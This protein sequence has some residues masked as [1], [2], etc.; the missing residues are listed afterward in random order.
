MAEFY[1]ARVCLSFCNHGLFDQT[2]QFA[3]FKIFQAVKQFSDL[4]DSDIYPLQ[5][6]I[7]GMHYEMT[8]SNFDFDMFLAYYSLSEMFKNETEISIVA[9]YLTPEMQDYFYGR[10]EETFKS[11]IQG[12]TNN[13]GVIKELDMLKNVENAS[14]AF[15][16]SRSP[17]GEVCFQIQC[18]D[19]GLMFLVMLLLNV[20]QMGNK[21]IISK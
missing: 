15:F 9:N 3:L 5:R 18:F 12:F 16:T 10:L 21:D 1:T 7:T 13:F 19:G 14:Q 11:K 2:K 8:I 17:G 4:D 6:L 20:P